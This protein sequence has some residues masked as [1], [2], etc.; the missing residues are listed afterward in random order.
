MI[1]REV[2]QRS[3]T[4]LSGKGSD[5]PRLEAELLL[6]HVLGTERLGLYADAHRRLGD[7]ELESLRGLLRRRA[8]GEPVA[9]LTGHREF[10]GLELEITRDV[11]VPRP[12]TELLVDRARELRPAR[13]LDLGTGSGC[14]AIA[15]AKQLADAAVTATDL[16]PAALEVAARNAARHGVADRIRFLEGDLFFALEPADLFDL[17]VSNPPYVA[18]G[19]AA[20]VAAHEPRLALYAGKQ[21]LEVIGRLLAGAG[22]HLAAG[23]TLLVEIGEDQEAA[24][25]ELAAAHF[26]HVGITHDLRRLPRVLEARA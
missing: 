24:V 5:A 4:W 26:G 20:G 9:Y 1:V 14:V 15:C 17:I 7:G 2:L 21:G 18:A 6:A 10:Y 23:G 13:I 3:A 19:E 11:L 8:D 12:E 25:R 16:S 22:G